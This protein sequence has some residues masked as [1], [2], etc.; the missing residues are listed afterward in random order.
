MLTNAKCCSGN[1]KRFL[2]ALQ[3]TRVKIVRKT[4]NILLVLPSKGAKINWYT[5]YVYTVRMRD[6]HK[7]KSS[8]MI[9][10]HNFSLKFG[11]VWLGCSFNETLTSIQVKLPNLFIGISISFREYSFRINNMFVFLK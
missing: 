5:Q 8:H 4:Q 11:L 10:I 6:T 1:F 7:M 3:R 9:H 2:H